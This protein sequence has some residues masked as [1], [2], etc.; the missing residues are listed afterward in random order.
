MF[1]VNSIYSLNIQRFTIKN[2]FLHLTQIKS[3]ENAEQT[4]M[5][6]RHFH[7]DQQSRQCVV[8]F[9]AFPIA[10]FVCTDCQV[11]SHENYSVESLLL[12]DF[13]CFLLLQLKGHSMLQSSN[14]TTTLLHGFKDSRMFFC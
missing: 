14:Y 8:P 1:Q 13:G 12:L 5:H 3:R 10:S 2:I 11:L 6:F 9:A 4:F 7:A